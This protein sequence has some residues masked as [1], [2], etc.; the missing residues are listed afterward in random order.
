MSVGTADDVLSE[1]F[2]ENETERSTLRVEEEGEREEE[3]EREEGQG[4]DSDEPAAKRA[5]TGPPPTLAPPTLSTPTHPV[6]I[7]MESFPT[8][9]FTEKSQK[10]PSHKPTFEYSVKVQGWEFTGSGGNKKDAKLS[11]AQNALEFLARQG[12]LRHKPHLLRAIGVPE[13]GEVAR[14]PLQDA[15]MNDMTI[16]KINNFITK[17]AFRLSEEV[18]CGQ[19]KVTAALIMLQTEVSP[20]QPLVAS[21]SPLGAGDQI[22]AIATG[23]KCISGIHL[24]EGGYALNDCHAEVVVRRAFMHFMYHQLELHKEHKGGQSILEKLENGKFSV[25]RGITFHLYIS[26]SPCGDGRVFSPNE[27][28]CTFLFGIHF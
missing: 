28:M 23:T 20:W 6:S 15:A 22:I 17:T 24:S 10:G 12:Y 9:E 21:L 18:Q 13:L 26:T 27:E 25:R 7:L 16:S 8:T 3:V 5:R 1:N 2:V 14:Q 4:E 19:P 11:A